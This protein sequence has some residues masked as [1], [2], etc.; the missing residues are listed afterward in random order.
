MEKPELEKVIE[1]L[2]KLDIRE[3]NILTHRNEI[4]DLTA[5]TKG[6]VVS[7]KLYESN[8]PIKMLFPFCLFDEMIYSIAIQDENQK[9]FIEYRD[10]SKKG[11]IYKFY[12]KLCKNLEKFKEDEF[13]R[14]IQDL[15]Y[16]LEP[17]KK[18]VEKIIEKLE[19]IDSKEWETDLNFKEKKHKPKY[20]EFV[21]NLYGLRFSLKRKIL[22][23]YVLEI[24]EPE[25]DVK[26]VYA[27]F[28]G[29]KQLYEKLYKELEN[30]EKE[31]KE[32]L[33]DFLSE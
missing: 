29:I 9:V 17:E 6:L 23:S 25:R 4:P 1:K 2:E 28:E 3:W 7:I 15:T 5:K 13:S 26:Q 18:D 30:K 12:E 27:L 11:K 20:P 10:D 22:G 33:D 19:N 8:N 21:L 31:F 24:K 14:R 16:G 32:K